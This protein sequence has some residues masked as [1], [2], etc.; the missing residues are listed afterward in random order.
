MIR[1]PAV[2][3]WLSRLSLDHIECFCFD[4]LNSI[5]RPGQ[6]AL[7]ETGGRIEQGTRFTLCRWRCWWARS[8]RS[9]AI[10]RRR[11]T[12]CPGY[13]YRAPAP[14]SRARPAASRLFLDPAP[15]NKGLS[16]SMSCACATLLQHHPSSSNGPGCTRRV[17]PFSAFDPTPTRCV[18]FGL[19]RHENR[20]E[21]R[22]Q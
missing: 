10:A 11:K 19:L 3:A 12:R 21:L 1:T 20:G 8:G 2:C 4:F 14:C 22:P 5:L 18:P 13:G 17:M 15:A 9:S 7:R 6:A 16:P